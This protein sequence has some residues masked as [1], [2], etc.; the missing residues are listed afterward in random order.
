MLLPLLL[1]SLLPLLLLPLLLLSA[2]FAFECLSAR[3]YGVAPAWFFWWGF[4]PA[5]NKSLIFRRAS[6][7]STRYFHA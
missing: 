6:A 3:S 2:S 1:L 4:A 5:L 7:V